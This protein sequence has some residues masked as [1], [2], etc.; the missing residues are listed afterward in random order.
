[1]ST[2][3]QSTFTDHDRLF[4]EVLTEFF[5]EFLEL[6]FLDV[7][8]FTDRNSL[9]GLDKEIFTDITVG[10]THEVDVLFRAKYENN[11]TV[12]LLH[13]E[14]Q[15][16]Y[17]EEFG[18]RMFK[19]F[20]RLFEKYDLAVYPIALFSYPSPKEAVSGKYLV[21]FPNKKVL[22]FDYD[23]VQ[24]NR[25][26]WRDFL[27]RPNPVASALMAKMNI[28]RRDRV[29]VKI[30]CLKMITGLNLNPAQRRLLSGFVDIY[31]KLNVRESRKFDDRDS[32]RAVGRT[33]G[34]YGI[35]YQLE[36]RRQN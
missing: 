18:K 36:R 9:I 33:G 14:P 16:Y 20:S 17:Q 21:V 19:Y 4:K 29:K 11:D 10:E 27:S 30:A 6:F 1:M 8:K 12:F 2:E 26:D 13:V 32:E 23:V 25:L 34:T 15:A 22:E 31:L 35:D 28:A 24:L 3:K 5:F 7:T